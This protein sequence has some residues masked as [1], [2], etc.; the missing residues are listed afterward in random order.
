MQLFS[1]KIDKKMVTINQSRDY[2]HLKKIKILNIFLFLTVIITLSTT[3]WFIYND[4]YKT[5]EQIKEITLIQNIQKFETI[6]FKMYEETIYAWQEKNL[7]LNTTLTPKRDL[8]NKTIVLSTSTLNIEDTTS[9]SVSFIV[10][11][12]R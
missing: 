8:F 5:L 7:A 3:F 10:E 2:T 4:V 11:P 6:N 12:S 9:T 1:K